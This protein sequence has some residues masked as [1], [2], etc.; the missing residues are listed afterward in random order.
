MD[1][2]GQWFRL[3]HLF[4]SLLQ[5]LLQE[6]LTPDEIA[7]VRRRASAWCAEHGL[8]D[9]AIDYALTSGDP[10][11]AV[12]MLVR[13]RYALMNAGHWRQLDRWLKRLP[14]DV[15]AQSLPL[16]SVQGYLAM[17][18]T[19]PWE[20]LAIYQQAVPLLTAR[21]PA[22]EEDQA[23]MV[24]LAV[25]KSLQD[26]AE[27]HFALVAADTRKTLDQLPARALYIR[28]VATTHIGVALQFAGEP[29]QC[30]STF[31]E[32]LS[33]P[34]WPAGAHAVLLNNFCIAQLLQGDLNGILET[35]GESLRF[36]EKSRLSELLSEGKVPPGHCSLLAQ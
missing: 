32:A 14:A 26:F 7:S 22:S 33:V 3:H 4:Q 9:E 17:Q 24:E 6:Q 36:A 35:A 16:L 15:V 13:H 11:A 18:R 30:A 31:R 2:Q 25:L 28:A 27:G 5:N 29:E 23:A 21:S 12:Q 8:L 34:G 19:A 10:A 20:A 1:D